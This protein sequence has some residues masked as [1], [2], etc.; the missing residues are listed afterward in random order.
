MA[1]QQLSQAC[2]SEG[3]SIARKVMADAVTFYLANGGPAVARAHVES[4]ANELKFYDDCTDAYREALAMISRAER[5]EQ[6]RAEERNQQQLMMTLM[7]VMQS[8]K[9][10]SPSAPAKDDKEA[11]P[12][13]PPKLSTDKALLIWQRLQQAGLID[14]HY[15]PVGLSR[16]KM[17]VIADEVM[18]LLADENEKLMGISDRWKHFETLWKKKNLRTDHYRNI[19]EGKLTDFKKEIQSLLADIQ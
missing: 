13:L 2:L 12:I 19:N 9:N 17:A 15:Q 7:G 14:E 8:G 11:A 18:T 5:Q 4:L 6:Q 3:F 16:A 1:N 10:D